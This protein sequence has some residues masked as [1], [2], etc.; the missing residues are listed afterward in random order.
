MESP[1]PYRVGPCNHVGGRFQKKR[2][3]KHVGLIK[4]MYNLPIYYYLSDLR[5]IDQRWL[6]YVG[7]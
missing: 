6:N 3:D 1:E 2:R 5:Y 4:G 7:L